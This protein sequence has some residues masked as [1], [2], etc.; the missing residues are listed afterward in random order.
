MRLKD[1]VILITGANSGIGKAVAERFATEGAHVGVNYR[2][3]G[4]SEA[5]ADD[6]VKSFSTE[7]M[8]LAADISKR[9]E[10]EKMVADLVAKFGRIDGIMCNAGIEKKVPFLDVTDDDWRMVIDVNLYG[11]FVCAQV[12]ARQMVKQGNGGRIVFTSSIHEDVPFPQYA[13]YCASKGGERMLM[14]NLAVELAQYKILCNNIAPGAIATPINQKVLD[15]PEMMK[16]ATQPIPLGRFG[17][18][19]EVA[20]LAVYLASDESSYTTGATF[21]LDGGLTQNVTKF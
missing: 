20:S 11:S 1:K 3:G 19:V 4:K 21:V 10:V 7:G 16:A 9:P 6:I 2:P 18:T 5:S 12:A 14:R 15:D 17:T 8:A 13:S